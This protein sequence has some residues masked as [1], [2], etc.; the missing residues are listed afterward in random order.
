LRLKAQ[1]KLLAGETFESV[2]DAFNDAAAEIDRLRRELEE[3]QEANKALRAKALEWL[4]AYKAESEVAKEERCKA[5]EEAAGIAENW[6]YPPVNTAHGI[7]D[8]IRQHVKDCA[9]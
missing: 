2:Y 7:A 5:F 9:E 3:A 1:G 6:K 8:A 4:N